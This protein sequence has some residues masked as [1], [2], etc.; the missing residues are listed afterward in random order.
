[1]PGA[2]VDDA[3]VVLVYC[4]TT[5]CRARY[6][7]LLPQRRN[8]SRFI[9]T[10]FL[11]SLYFISCFS[12]P[13]FCRYVFDC[14]FSMSLSLFLSL[15]FVYQNL[16]PILLLNCFLQIVP[17]VSK[18]FAIQFQSTIFATQFF[19]TCARLRKLCCMIHATKNLAIKMLPYNVSY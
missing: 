8:L 14:S 13:F 1:M 2:A 16:H 7:V 15:V 11:L 4:S 10:H 3:G 6:K 5:A 18:V 19:V 12:F 9:R 17:Q